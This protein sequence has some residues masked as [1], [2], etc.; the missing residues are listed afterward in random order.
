M[1][2]EFSS[3]TF[4]DLISTLI[5]DIT[6]INGADYSVP[7]VSNVP[8]SFYMFVPEGEGAAAFESNNN[9]IAELTDG[10]ENGENFPIGP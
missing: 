1:Q 10:G 9:T 3:Q 6:D 8:N 7:L 2:N 4:T 5:G